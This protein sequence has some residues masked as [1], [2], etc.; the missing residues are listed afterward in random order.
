MNSSRAP[1]VGDI[2][3]TKDS[4]YVWSY[5][6]DM[7][8]LDPTLIPVNEKIIITDIKQNA[9]GDFYVTFSHWG[10]PYLC[11]L[12]PIREHCELIK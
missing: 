3:L 5:R 1:E 4:F 6:T 9:I 8:A 2:Y 11:Y 12:G 10:T 7:V